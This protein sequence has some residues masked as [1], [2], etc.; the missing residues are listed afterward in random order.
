VAVQVFADLGYE[1]MRHVEDEDS[2]LCDCFFE[3]GCRNDVFRQW[4]VGEV[5]NVL[6]D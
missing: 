1:L 3:V 5:F 6:V 2:S 4:D